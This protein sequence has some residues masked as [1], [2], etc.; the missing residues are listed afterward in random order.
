MFRVS[1][2]LSESVP[3]FPPLSIALF[4]FDYASGG[5]EKDVILYWYSPEPRQG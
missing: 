4:N 2:H 5:G 1:I 3:S